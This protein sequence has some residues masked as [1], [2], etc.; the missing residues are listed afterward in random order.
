MSLRYLTAG[1]SH[2]PSLTVIL[3][4]FPAGVPV[5]AARIDRELKR[6]MGGHGRGGRMKIEDDLVE[7]LSGVRFGESLGSPIAMLIRNRDFVNWQQAMNPAGPRP[8]GEAE[9]AEGGAIEDSRLADDS[10]PAVFAALP[11]AAGAAARVREVSRPDRRG[12][13]GVPVVRRKEYEMA[14]RGAVSQAVSAMSAGCEKRLAVL[15]VV[16]RRGNQYGHGA[17]I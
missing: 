9:R 17:S 16:L 15:R 13:A 10:S 11:D 7:I 6:R 5:D 12:D 4:G 2:G 3:E 8:T 14:R 1:E